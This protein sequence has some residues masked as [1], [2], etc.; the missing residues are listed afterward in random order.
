MTQTDEHDKHD[1]L[2]ADLASDSGWIKITGTM[3]AAELRRAFAEGEALE[4]ERIVSL[5]RAG[6]AQVL[7][8]SLAGPLRAIASAIESDEVGQ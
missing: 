7:P 6:A 2:A 5:L 3:F 8:P 4:R 1:K